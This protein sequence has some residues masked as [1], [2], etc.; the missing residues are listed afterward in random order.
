MSCWNVA[1]AIYRFGESELADRPALVHEDLVVSYRELRR[2]AC[3]IASYL[4]AQGLPAGAHVGHY[5]RN[6]N[7]YLETF[8]GAGLAG[9]SHINVNY[10]YL[11]E[12][13]LD[14]CNGLDV[15][16]LVFDSEFRERVAAIRPQLEKTAVFIEVGSGASD[17]FAVQ[18]DSLYDH[19]ISK[20]VRQTSSDDLVLIATGGTTGLPKGTQWRHEDLWRKMN[21]SMGNDLMVLDLKEHPDNLDEHLA[22]VMLL[23]PG[24]GFLSLS[25]L[26]HGA[27]LMMALLMLCQGRPL[28]TLSG[29]RFDADAT[30]TA[31]KR[32]KVSGMV[33]VGDAF[34]APLLEALDRRADE[35]TLG[36][37]KMLVSS[38]ASLSPEVRDGLLRHNPQLVVFDTLGS[39]EASGYALSTPEAG[40]FMLLP[41]TRILDD[42]LRDVVPGSDTIGMAYSGGY[43]PIG[44]Y[45]SPEKS[46]ETF[47]EIDGQRYVMTGDRCT[48]RE[49]GKLILLGRDSTVVNT[50]GEKVYTVEVERILVDHPAITDALVVGMPHPR[51]GK[52]VVAVVEGPGLDAQ[53]LDVES[54]QQHCASHLAD[55]KVPRKIFA[56]ESLQRAPN[57]KPDYAFINDYAQRCLEA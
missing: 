8:T 15:Q 45:K 39:T 32:H 23:P 26:M 49:D 27:G 44:Y 25:P 35:D 47:V 38:G 18:L 51:F 31:I 56:I 2:R 20:F 5:M 9:M 19:D 24:S 3:G 34:A 41:N 16:V 33:L 30:L 57:G 37:L 7:A 6:S 12:E 22:N 14:L 50:G 55:Y 13:L 48:L 28:V 10:R 4:Q 46:A 29:V 36:S 21:T 43:Q 42:Q 1:E 11:D 53:S 52:M 54:V 40:V 17:D